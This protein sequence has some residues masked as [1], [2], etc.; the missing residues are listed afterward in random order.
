MSR[1]PAPVEILAAVLSGLVG[2]VLSVGFSVAMR[3]FWHTGT[4]G[5]FDSPERIARLGVSFVIAGFLFGRWIGAH[6]ATSAVAALPSV[7]GALVLAALGGRFEPARLGL[8]AATFG[9]VSG[10]AH[11]IG[12]LLRRAISPGV[13]ES[14]P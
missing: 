8:T 9:A 4:G 7:A 11:W 5:G 10:A 2:L 13:D 6:V 3:V 14:V 12:C 1:R